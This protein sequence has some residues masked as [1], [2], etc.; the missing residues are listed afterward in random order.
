MK[1]DE[2]KKELKE[3]VKKI[4]EPYYGLNNKNFKR[5]LA[6]NKNDEMDYIT[7]MA[8]IMNVLDLPSLYYINSVL[9]QAFKKELTFAILKK[10]ELN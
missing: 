7:F 6:K 10:H 1:Y 4:V 8:L 5:A 2:H 9:L 3:L